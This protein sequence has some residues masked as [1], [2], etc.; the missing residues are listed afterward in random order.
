MRVSIFPRYLGAERDRPISVSAVFRFPD[1]DA[2]RAES[3]ALDEAFSYGTPA[4]VSGE[5]VSNI[6][7]E[8]IAGLDEI[9]PS[10][11]LA[12]GPATP[13]TP[14]A[15]PEIA[16]QLID[17]LGIISTQ[18]PLRVIDRSI[19]LQGGVVTLTD[20]AGAIQVKMRLNAVTHQFNL[21]Y[22]FS[23]LE[24]ILPAA[25]LPPL[26]FLLGLSSGLNLLVL[27]NGE[28]QGPPVSE[29]KEI[30]DELV[31]Y[32]MVATHLD[33]LQRKSRVYFDMPTSLSVDELEDIILARRLLDGE[34]VHAEWKSSKMTMP[35]TSLDGL[36]ELS[37][38]ATRTLWARVPHVLAIEGQSYPLGYLLRTQ[39]SARI[40]KW[41]EFA[42]DIS[43]DAEIE[44]TFIPGNNADVAM[45]L[46][47]RDE[48]ERAFREQEE[49][50]P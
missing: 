13:V 49:S 24:K 21:T 11:R 30:L 2:G 20:H 10:G 31:R 46:L 15:L 29:K 32:E 27:M 40:E 5:F 43:P 50:H 22:H 35:A 45:R 16:L 4:V 48:L 39:S 38:G 33:E 47:T 8:G 12:F 44:V 26:R 23:S 14:N 34:T 9:F 25:I 18:L 7:I 42:P 17:E 41:P 36:Q 28:P 19:G 1:T 6:R 3:T 37:T